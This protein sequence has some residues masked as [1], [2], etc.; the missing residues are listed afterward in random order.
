MHGTGNMPGSSEVDSPLNYADYYYLEALS[1]YR[2]VL[3]HSPIVDF[4]FL[5]EDNN[6]PLKI[7]FDASLTADSDNDS[8]TYNWD[9]GDS[10]K[11]FSLSNFI[12]HVYEKPGIYSVTLTTNDKWNGMD[13]LQQSVVVKDLTGIS[14]L[15]NNALSVYPNPASD[16][17]T[18]ILPHQYGPTSVSIANILGQTY[19][20]KLNPGKNLIQSANW[21]DS[22]Y[23][24]YFETHDGIQQTKLMIKNE[25]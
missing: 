1:R 14:Q 8:L 16:S 7:N 19:Q 10:K 18:I 23:L 24:I 22:L 20:M 11:A 13:T 4:S 2:R 15:E 25:G 17:F 21:K 12:S 3:N 9:F 6:S 5:Q